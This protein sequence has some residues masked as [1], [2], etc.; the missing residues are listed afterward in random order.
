MHDLFVVQR[1]SQCREYIAL[2]DMM[3]DEVERIR[4]EVVVA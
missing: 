3:N 1:R 2:D 4:K